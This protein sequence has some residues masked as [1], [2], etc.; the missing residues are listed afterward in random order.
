MN[1]FKSMRQWTWSVFVMSLLALALAGCEG[2]T[3]PQGPPGPAGSDGQDAVDTGSIS[4]TVTSSGAA[5]EGATVS[6][7]PATTTADTDATGVAVIADIAIGVYDVT[8]SLGGIEA[9]QGGVSVVAGGTADVSLTLF[10]VPGTIT[11]KVVGPDGDGDDV[12]DPVEGATVSTPGSVSAVTDA[13]GD[14]TLDSVTRSFLSV[15]PPAGAS[16][17]PG[18]T[19]HSVSPG[20]TVQIELSGRPADD[21]TFVSN[22][23]CVA[24]HGAMSPGLI[25]AWQSSGHYRVVERSLVEMDTSGWPADPGLDTCS[26]WAD[27]G[28][29]ANDVTEPKTTTPSH[30]VYIRTCNA[31][32][33]LGFEVLVDGDDN[34]ADELVDTLVTV[35]ATYG[36][37]GS[38]AGELTV[39]QDRGDDTTVN[40]S[41]ILGVWKQRYMFNIADLGTCS[42][43]NPEGT[44]TKPPKP[45]FV[46]WD[47][48]QT[49]EDM[50]LT[51]IQ[52]NQRTGA[53]VSYHPNDWYTQGRTYSKKC[54]GCHEAGLTLAADAAGNV[55]QYVAADY[56]IGCQKCHGPGSGH[57]AGAGDVTKIINP[58]YMTA[59]A[60]RE[61]CGQCHSRGSE[62]TIADIGG[63]FGFPWRSDVTDFDGNFIAGIH[64]LDWDATEAPDGYYFQ[65]PGLWDSGYSVKHHQQYNDFLKSSHIDNPWEILTCYDCHSPHSGRGGPFRFENEDFAGNEFVFGD[66][67]RANMSNVRCLSCHASH[68]PF[69]TLTLDDIAVYHT[70]RGGTVDKN[71]VALAPTPT[72]QTSAE[73]LVEQAVKAHS[74]EAAGMPIAPYLPEESVIPANYGFGEGPVGRC[75]ACH[76]TKTAK[77]ATWF[78]DPSGLRIEGDASSHV[79]DIVLPAPG[80]DQPN[81]C[82]KCH[83]FF[84]TEEPTPP[85]ED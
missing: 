59:K 40:G 53:W 43:T 45:A 26:A 31:A 6:T 5:V 63:A 32:G 20:E 77:S 60:S 83:G 84:R 14:F 58:N 56:R 66:N 70:A 82:G 38:A 71:G 18:E 12:P 21:A 78:D 30:D 55:T 23:T 61:L 42:P 49:C 8:A 76:M 62:P 1:R 73:D 13:N 24:C 15:E 37:P 35:Y 19:R 22:D 11:G 27:T 74:G 3:G 16:L 51:P 57:I 4:V 25:A 69:S 17:L 48:T 79:F 2:D 68:G 80:T 64:T 81:A 50:L 10:G 41:P 44:A 33:V 7:S 67:A 47:T 75:T 39:L 34:G 28:V 52:Y 46:T 29:D 65:D 72:E 54:S 9:T 85:G 36:G